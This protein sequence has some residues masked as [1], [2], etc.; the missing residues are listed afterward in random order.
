LQQKF[1]PYGQSV[2]VPLLLRLPGAI[3]AS[4][5]VEEPVSCVDL[6]ATILDYAGVAAPGSHGRSLRRM[7]ESSSAGESTPIF[8]Q[9]RDWYVLI[10]ADGWK[11][12]W[13]NR[14]DEC[15]LLFDLKKDPNELTNLVG[16]C[17][18]R[19]RHAGQ[20]NRMKNRLLAWMEE[21][22][23]PWRDRCARAAIK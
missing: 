12:V 20:A 8:A 7:V 3:P 18:D 14:P 6:F 9:F 22:A 4:R 2:R 17:P 11:Y 10:Q 16:A 5:V 21:T 19:S 1:V 15:D 23:H 13:N